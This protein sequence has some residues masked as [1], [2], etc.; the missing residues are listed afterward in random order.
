M[1]LIVRQNKEQPFRFNQKKAIQAVAFLLRQN[2]ETN[3][4]DNYMRL[5]KLLLFADRK[6]L[7]ETGRPITG[8][9]FVAMKCGP[10]LSMLLDLVKQEGFNNAEW[11]EYIRRDGFN[12]RLIKDP[13]ND[14]LCRYEMDLLNAI[15]QKHREDGEWAVAEES[16]KLPEFI[17]NNPGESSKAIPLSDVL[18]AI[19]KSAWLDDILNIAEE[20]AGIDDVLGI[21]R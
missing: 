4:S 20:D 11:N 5:L 21:S 12:I 2:P 3:F 8:D 19:G 14:E 1:S 16:E 10:T 9:R 17:K 7:E 18:E 13:G 6:S 15:W